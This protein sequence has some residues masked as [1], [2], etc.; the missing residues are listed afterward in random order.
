MNEKKFNNNDLSRINLELRLV[1]SASKYFAF[2]LLFITL[3]TFV[4][5]IGFLSRTG[6]RMGEYSTL[7]ELHGNVAILITIIIYSFVIIGFFSYFKVLD[8]ILDRRNQIKV[9]K[10][11]KVL[12]INELS[13]KEKNKWKILNK[14]YTHE[15]YISYQDKFYFDSNIHPEL[16]SAKTKEIEMAKNSKIILSEKYY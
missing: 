4:I 11:N 3:G 12:N 9:I 8:L 5:P 15:L 1:L 14:S 16:L 7:Y 6:R 2:F 13:E 10:K